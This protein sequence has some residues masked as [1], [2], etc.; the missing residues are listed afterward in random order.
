MT[1]RNG[2][3]I[4]IPIGRRGWIALTLVLLCALGIGVAGGMAFN[5]TKSAAQVSSTTD[6]SQPE[7]STRQST[8]T[9]QPL[10]SST[11]QSASTTGTTSDRTTRSQ[12]STTST[13]RPLL[14]RHDAP[15]VGAAAQVA[16]FTGGI[17]G[18]GCEGE[19]FL[20]GGRARPAIAVPGGTDQHPYNG[21]ISVGVISQFC[22]TGFRKGKPLTVELEGPTG[23]VR[24]WQLCF[25][26][27]SGYP[28]DYEPIEA[29]KW[30]TMPG[31]PLGRYTA[32]FQQEE[33]EV[34]GTVTLLEASQPL[35]QTALAATN[36]PL[37]EVMDDQLPRPVP[38][39]TALR[40]GL[41]GYPRNQ[42]VRINIY[43]GKSNIGR[44]VS[45][46]LVRTNTVGHASYTLKTRRE[47]PRGCYVLLTIPPR[48]DDPYYT[49][50]AVFRDFCLT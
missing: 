43:F 30:S 26:C 27:D 22:F 46:L 49:G 38:A 34:T 33:Q 13:T 7:Q 12:D 20:M 48:E 35:L 15:P 25:G 28:P 40:L 6:S 45:S 14:Q 9:S 8:S 19:E 10:T 37:R 18:P 1:G 44:Y 29:L 21:S 31:D 39:G 16:F 11:A 36:E 41:V 17:G 23:I 3:R 50:K 24:N 32:T 2:P 5:L 47:D 42:L 4:T